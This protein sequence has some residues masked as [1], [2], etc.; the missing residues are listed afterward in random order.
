MKFKDADLIGIPWRLVVGRG[1]GERSVEL[2]DRSGGTGKRDLSADAALE[3]L[4][5]QLGLQGASP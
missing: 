1:A 5:E 2:M 4:M 3:Q